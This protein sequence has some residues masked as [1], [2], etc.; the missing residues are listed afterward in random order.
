MRNSL[1]L[2]FILLLS[3]LHQETSTYAFQQ[4]DSIADEDKLPPEE[5]IDEP[6]TSKYLPTSIEDYNEAYYVLSRLNNPLGFPS[7]K[8]NLQT[9]QA[10]L[11]HFVISCRNEN[12]QDAAHALNLNLMPNTISVKEAENLAQ[13]LYY[14]LDQRV[15]INWD[16]LPDRP[17]GQIDIRTTTNQEVAGQPRRSIVFGET[18][19]E[20]RDIIFRV[21]RIKYKDYGAIWLISAN[22]VENTEELYQIY[23][24]TFLDRHMPK[25]SQA[26]IGTVPLWKPVLTILL[27]LF[28]YLL[29]RIVILLIRKIAKSLD[30]PLILD[31][32]KRL[33]VPAAMAAGVLFFYITLNNLISYSGMFSSTI[34]AILLAI[35]IAS[36]TWFFMRIIDFVMSYVAENKIG[37]ITSEDSQEARQHF[38]YFSVARRILTF[39]V[40]IIGTSIILSQFKSLE[41][42]GIS[43]L[44]SAGLATIILG[45]SA[46]STLGNIIAGIQIAITKPARI[47]DTVIF[48]DRWGYVEDIRFTYMV[49]RTWDLKRLIIPLKTVI[50]ETFENLSITSPPQL[51]EIELFVDYRVDVDKLRKKFKELLENSEEWDQE[52]PP[53]L[54]VLRMTEKSLQIRAVCSAKNAVVAWDLHCKLREQMGAYINELEEGIYFTRSRVEV[55]E[56]K[57]HGDPDKPDRKT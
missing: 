38:T 41:K 6:E 16:A 33:G 44:A 42:L 26:N 32:S 35:A 9:P 55:K 46:Q 28:S 24:P 25:W 31:L 14:V 1:R 5:K 36:V 8:F 12:F 45:I 30:R 51:F 49:V 54:Q 47:G 48:E 57:F 20:N 21:Q 22:T 7:N 19:I 56:P 18:Q 29:G 23:G 15:D 4:Q 27:I 53:L 11:E 3:F 10:T 2:V 52:H 13:K 34:Y 37:D 50:S 17:D 43:M 40:L 39:A